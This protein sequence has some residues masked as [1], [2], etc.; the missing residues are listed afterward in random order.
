MEL[1]SRVSGFLEPAAGMPGKTINMSSHGVLISFDRTG[2][3]PMTL[4]MGDAARV[5]LELPN[6]PYFR[7]C[8]LECTCRVVRVEKLADA[9]RIAFDVKR[10]QFRPSPQAVSEKL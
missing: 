3:P 7:G 8:R 4:A 6:A 9:H 5:V 10:Y 1:D 2:P